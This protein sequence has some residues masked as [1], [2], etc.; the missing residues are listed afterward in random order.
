MLV[1]TRNVQERLFIQEGEIK[2]TVLEIKGHQVRLG[3]EAPKCITIHREE[4][5]MSIEAAKKTEKLI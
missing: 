1:L 3:I 2:I 5:F 4:V